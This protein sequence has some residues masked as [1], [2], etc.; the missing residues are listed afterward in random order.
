MTTLR[1]FAGAREA[2]G[3]GR[4]EVDGQTVGDVLDA[5]VA[6][7]G[8][9]FAVVLESCRVWVNGEPAT[10]ADAVTPTDEVAV[11][12]PVSGG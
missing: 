3:T 6:R 5:A 9:G 8:A 12:P 2:A 4:A 11:L 7:Y 10:R 1:L